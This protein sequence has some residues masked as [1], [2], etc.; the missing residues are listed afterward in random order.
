MRTLNLPAAA[1][2]APLLLFVGAAFAQAPAAPASAAASA[3]AGKTAPSFSLP[4]QNDRMRSLSQNRGKWVVLA[5]YPK[6]GTKG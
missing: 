2:V 3:L 6:D 4:D 1:V 5:F